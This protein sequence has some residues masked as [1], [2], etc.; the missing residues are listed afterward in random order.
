ML[1]KI[2]SIRLKFQNIHNQGMIELMFPYSDKND[3]TKCDD[4]KE[5]FGFFYYSVRLV[6]Y[7]KI[8]DKLMFTIKCRKCNKINIRERV[9]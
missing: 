6:S 4:C 3:T 2:K 9:K 7:R 8:N 5:K 1:D